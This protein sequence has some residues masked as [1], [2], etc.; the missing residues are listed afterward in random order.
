[1]RT[2]S[3]YG[4][5]WTRST[6]RR[7]V[8]A[9]EFQRCTRAPGEVALFSPARA[10]GHCHQRSEILVL[11]ERRCL[12]CWSKPIVGNWQVRPVDPSPSGA[13]GGGMQ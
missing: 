10:C 6:I 13:P 4:S 1:M 3:R 8:T 12:S 11:P 7:A 5:V 9:L 2:P